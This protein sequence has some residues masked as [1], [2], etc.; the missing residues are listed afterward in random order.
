MKPLGTITMFFPFLD[1]DTN[2][3][4]QSL[5]DTA[6][7]YAD[8][9]D[10]LQHH[11]DTED[12]PEVQVYLAARH[13]LALGDF[14]KITSL[15]G[16]YPDSNL[17]HVY[18]LLVHHYDQREESRMDEI[19]DAATNILDI[20]PD[21]WIAFDM[22]DKILYALTSWR[23]NTPT[24]IVSYQEHFQKMKNLV[25]SDK[26]LSCF[27]PILC[28]WAAGWPGEGLERAEN[29]QR[30]IEIAMEYDDQ[31]SVVGS[32]Q[33]LALLIRNYGE[34]TRALE[35]LHRA[36]EINESL[37]IRYRSVTVL[38]Y[39]GIVYMTRGEYNAAA[40]LILQEIRERE[41][42][43]QELITA[44]AATLGNIY[45]KMGD[46]EE[47]L[48][49]YK[50]CK[51]DPSKSMQHFAIAR[52]PI[53]LIHL[54]RYDEARKQLEDLHER[55]LRMGGEVS[56]ML[57]YYSSGLLEQIEGDFHSAMYNFGRGF[58][59]VERLA[60]HNRI[61]DCLLRLTEC[62]IALLDSEGVDASSDVSGPWMTRLFDTA[63]DEFPG[64]FGLALLLKAE[65]RLKQERRE[66]AH[67]LMTEV[68]KLGEHS[69]MRFLMDRVATLRRFAE[70]IDS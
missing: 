5:M 62:E 45:T 32:I 27:E 23:L 22:L 7:N 31:V 39:L 16:K 63:A 55:T 33:L 11:V 42:Y 9:V 64:I 35:L 49:W 53:A 47:A 3:L 66:E 40:D 46:G 15:K 50:L 8:F 38:R 24:T 17:L 19:A 58:D 13:A 44:C 70:N 54:G 57:L 65:L 48:A 12:T 28:R 43:P 34:T 52:I 2:S 67:E 37:G 1:T 36:K 4:L 61:N 10:R 29:L 60:I 18:Y 6:Y 59:I 56:L 68:R 41:K 26:T 25:E 20:N 30:A 14:K 69:S 21:N 51:E